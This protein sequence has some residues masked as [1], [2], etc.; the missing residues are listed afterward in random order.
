MHRPAIVKTT[1]QLPNRAGKLMSVDVHRAEAGEGR[2]P[3]VVICHSFMA[4]KEW[5]FFPRVAAR[6]AEFGF[7]SV[8]FNF[9]HNGVAADGNRIT[10]F[11]SFESNTF[12]QELDDLGAI[13]DGLSE[14][15]AIPV[16]ADGSPIA[17]LGHSR[18]GG[19]AIVYAADDPRIGAVA[20]WSAIATFDRW[21]EH[22]RNMWRAAGHLPLSKNTTASPLR[23][24]L[25]IL[26][27]V[28]EHG[29]RLS[30]IAAAARLARPL[31]VIHGLED[32][33]VPVREA[34]S[35]FEAADPEH[36]EIR[37]L[38]HTGHL[39]HAASPEEDNYRTLD[40]IIE[41]TAHWLHR[42]LT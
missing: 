33:T 17:L 23:L 9:S 37:L 22:Q 21:T 28:E 16:S 15:G 26:R 41:T 42:T 36:T 27:D 12:T 10:D 25:G 31:L 14:S 8:S 24:G 35:L 32:V 40:G 11:E 4:F 38:E 29:E 1:L 30:I 20:T 18:G 5:G 3:V 39:Y 34:E 6:L 2:Q 13:I 7:V 19:I